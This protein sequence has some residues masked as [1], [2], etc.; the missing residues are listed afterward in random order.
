[1]KKKGIRQSR[2][3]YIKRDIRELQKLGF[4]REASYYLL[5][6]NYI[7]FESNALKIDKSVFNC[8]KDSIKNECE[9][10]RINIPEL[11]K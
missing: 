10:L 4:S 7:C 6:N 11:F 5:K 1:M 3:D 8:K 2:Q 9:V